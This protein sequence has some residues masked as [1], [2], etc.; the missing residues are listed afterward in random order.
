MYIGMKRVNLGAMGKETTEL[1]HMRRRLGQE[2]PI[3]QTA[4][5]S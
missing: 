4:G 5:Q 3:H 1:L 2:D